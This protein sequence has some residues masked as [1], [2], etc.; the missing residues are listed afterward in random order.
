MIVNGVVRALSL[1]SSDN[2]PF[3]RLT[4]WRTVR[5]EGIAWNAGTANT[6]EVVT[7][8]TGFP[9]LGVDEI[10]VSTAADLAAAAPHRV[11]LTLSAAE[12][13]DLI[14]YLGSLDAQD[15]TIHK[16]LSDGFERGSTG[17]WS[18]ATQ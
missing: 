7:R 18:T 14:A 15:G 2:D 11:A 9:R 5:L 13:A 3:W 8:G 16:L 6:V 10:V 12:R 4:N 17:A 1:P